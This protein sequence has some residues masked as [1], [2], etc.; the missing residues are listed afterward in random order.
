MFFLQV[1]EKEL[2]YRED[3]ASSESEA[4][5]EDRLLVLS[6]LMMTSMSA[7]AKFDIMAQCFEYWEDAEF[8]SAIQEVADQIAGEKADR[9]Q[10]NTA[11]GT[12][13]GAHFH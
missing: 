8:L 12:Y 7:E 2:L 3:R 10:R 1:S 6:S 4:H 9:I 5:Y 13:R 11:S